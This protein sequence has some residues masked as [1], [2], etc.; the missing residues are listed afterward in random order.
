MECGC[1]SGSFDSSTHLLSDGRLVDLSTQSIVSTFGMESIEAIVPGW[2][3]CTDL[4]KQFPLYRFLVSMLIDPN[5]SDSPFSSRVSNKC[6]LISSEFSAK[7]VEN[8][9]QRKIHQ[10]NG[11]ISWKFRFAKWTIKEW[12]C[13]QGSRESSDFIKWTLPCCA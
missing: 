9:F 11:N 6:K 7:F 8:H 10:T 5:T 4:C 13:R 1:G 12:N 2:S 3:E